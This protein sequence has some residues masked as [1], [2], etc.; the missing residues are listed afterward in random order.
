MRRAFTRSAA[1]LSALVIAVV[2]ASSS[3]S[4]AASRIEGIERARL[5]NRIRDDR[6]DF[7]GSA[8]AVMR[9]NLRESMWK[10]AAV[11]T[12]PHRIRYLFQSHFWDGDV[13]LY[14]WQRQTAAE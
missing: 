7:A 11:T 2:S 14:P 12:E 6:E 4:S 10:A 5:E 1:I 3:S 13:G 8:S 9:S